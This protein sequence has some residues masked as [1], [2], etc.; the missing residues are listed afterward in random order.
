MNKQVILLGCCFLTTTLAPLTS[1]TFAQANLTASGPRSTVP[2]DRNFKVHPAFQTQWEDY[3]QTKQGKPVDIIFIGDSITEQWRWGGGKPVWK[4]H[5]ADRA[6]NFGQGS[7][8]TQSALWRLE[9]LDIKGF[10]PKVAVVLIGTNNFNDTPEDIAAA[11]TLSLRRRS[12][13]LPV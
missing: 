4:K 12:R 13:H 10:K 8:M 5:F 1:S 9:N 2:N 3:L 6:L 11:S 7:D